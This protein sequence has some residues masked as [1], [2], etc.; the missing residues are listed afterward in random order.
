MPLDNA[1]ARVVLGRT[2]LQTSWLGLGTAPLGGLFAE[3]SEAQ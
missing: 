2:G 1:L 3:V